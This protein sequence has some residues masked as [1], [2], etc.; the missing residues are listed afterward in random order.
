MLPPTPPGEPPPL[1]LRL[2]GAPRLAR[3]SR[4][5]LLERKAAGALAWLALRGPVLRVRLA[6]LL[7]PSASPDGARNN[8]RQLIFKLK[9][10]MDA[11]V[12]DGQDELRLSP[13]LQRDEPDAAGELLEGCRFDDCPSFSA[14]LEDARQAH[15]EQV[16]AARLQAI[17]ASLAQ[18]NAQRA[19][20]LARAAV[21]ADE[22]SE[23]A[24][25][26][27]VQALYLAGDRAAALEAAA[28]FEARLRDALDV[29]PSAELQQLVQTLRSAE[30]PAAASSVPV[31]VLRPPRLIGR[32]RER[33]ALQRAAADGQV[34]ML[35]GEP[36]LG[37]SRLLA[38]CAADS[39][40]ALVSGAR[41]GDAGVPF[42]AL[43]RWLRALA[44]QYPDVVAAA[45]PAVHRVL[46]DLVPMTSG[47]SPLQLQRAL[48]A[49]VGAAYE[50]G[51]TALWLD[52][53]HFADDAS[54]DALQGLIGA[55][56]LDRLNWVLAQ[57]PGEG[58][59]GVQALANT[60]L[61][62]GRLQPLL[63]HPLDEAQIAEL[64]DSLGL[65][66]VAGAELAA[67]LARATGGNP[68]FVL[69]MLKA[70][71]VSPSGDPFAGQR[72]RSVRALMERRLRQ[73]SPPA[74]ALARVAAL[75]GPDFG[76]DLA[77]H[78]LATPLMALADAWAELEAAQ[79]LR[80]SVFAHD[81]VYE[82]TL[83][84]VPPAIRRHARRAIAEFLAP[85]D[86]EPSRLAE[87]WLAAGEPARAAPAF[88]AAGRRAEAAARYAEAR[89]LLERSAACHDSAGQPQQ[90][91]DTRLALADLLMEAGQFE[92]SQQVL[93]DLQARAKPVDDQ[94][95]V[96]MAQMQLMMR[97]DREA[98]A[99]ALGVH[100]LADEVVL[101]DATPRR[102][103]ELRWT[104]ATGYRG[105]DRAA[106]ALE[107]LQLADPELSASDDPTWR[108]WQHS[109]H[110]IVLNQLG[111]VL[112]AEA[113]QA[114]AVEA[115]RA[116]GRKRM[117][118]G[119]LQNGSTIATR[120]GDLTGALD[121]LDESLLLMSDTGGD[122]H[123]ST[124][125]KAQRARLLVWLGRYGEAIEPLEALAADGSPVDADT[126]IL[127]RAALAKLWAW[128]GQPSRGRRVLPSVSAGV[129]FPATRRALAQAARELGWMQGPA[130]AAASETSA[131]EG[132]PFAGG[133]PADACELLQ[134]ARHWPAAIDAAELA[135][136][137]AR[138][139][140]S[141]RAGHVLAA[142]VVAA[143]LARA[144]GDTAAA[145]VRAA[146][147]MQALRRA[148]VL[149]FYRPAL[150][151]ELAR[152]AA[153]ADPALSQRALRDGADW[154]RNVARFQVPEP[155]RDSFLKR[156]RINRELL[157][158]AAASPPRSP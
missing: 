51:L 97:S 109:Q 49:L 46:P 108:C 118:A 134:R 2:T 110:A 7:W 26:R 50:A 43:A 89:Q 140:A 69:E 41:P 24:R 53:L 136:W 135:T 61:D 15:R 144:R 52:D 87:H 22:L 42:S 91:L 116:V 31:T 66:G 63:L 21:A 70:R 104:L 127:S 131:D 74:L 56:E 4:E 23:P 59:P 80:D 98:D 34:V 72:P 40:G 130:D 150:L 125:V 8:L 126:R 155:M 68:L 75:A 115:A 17:D 64:V 93:D 27:L 146:A 60:L 76:T 35:S 107:Q 85:R 143:S 123:F 13:G 133:E 54:L 148:A 81:L 153:P 142:D 96:R 67:P 20:D 62:D 25:L 37:K 30:V 88:E 86:A 6:E 3:G 157:A 5:L 95:R 132:E 124:F 149:G 92:A 29:E 137:R 138:W 121:R 99:I 152:A 83:D 122:D 16:A 147:A 145:A 101:E 156:N 73:L 48:V 36:G 90:A 9:R 78:V 58:R 111:E 12:I 14:W 141:G 38:D 39:P 11:P 71:L 120:A 114:Q 45:A 18:G 79:V 151:L 55:P 117:I 82:A 33:A 103:A 19:V 57:R 154:V 10:A 84:S 94:L 1:K 100:T 77:Q 112:R 119:C 44:D 32:G 128:L 105:I 65:P 158:L 113:V 28:Q 106:E 47:G 102:L 139:D 129:Y